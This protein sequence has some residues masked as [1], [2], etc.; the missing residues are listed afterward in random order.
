MVPK[1]DFPGHAASDFPGF[2]RKFP[3]GGISNKLTIQGALRLRL[4]YY[5][6]HSL[7]FFWTRARKFFFI[8]FERIQAGGCGPARLYKDE[9]GAGRASHYFI[10]RLPVLFLPSTIFAIMT[11]KTAAMRINFYP[12]IVGV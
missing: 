10:G 12:A 6:H 4:R 7:N 1:D 2:L 11:K 5:W 8:M 3:C 9:S